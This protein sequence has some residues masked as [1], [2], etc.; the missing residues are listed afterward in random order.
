[1]DNKK[2][3]NREGNFIQHMI[4]NLRRV[5]NRKISFTLGYNKNETY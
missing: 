4:N 5:T 1:M 3:E 2:V